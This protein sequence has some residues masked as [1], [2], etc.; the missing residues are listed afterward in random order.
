MRF[1]PLS[2][3][4]FRFGLIGAGTGFAY[5]VCMAL[6]SGAVSIEL[7]PTVAASSVSY[8]IA[9]MVSYAGHKYFTF[10]A[11]GGHAFELPR[12]AVLSGAGLT[13][14]TTLPFFTGQLGLPVAVPIMLTCVIIP[15]VNY[16]VLRLWVFRA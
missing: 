8:T 14:A 2:H 16:A 12:F 10:A 15:I 9:A 4:A 3:R 13:V 1:V 5:V 6:L 7:L 11:N